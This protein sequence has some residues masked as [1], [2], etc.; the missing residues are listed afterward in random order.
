MPGGTR[1]ILE[2]WRNLFAQVESAMGWESV[3]QTWPHLEITARLAAR[4]LAVLRTMMERG[5]NA[6]LTSSAGRLFD[7]VAASLGLGG[8]TI[9]YEGQAAIELEA[10]AAGAIGDA[11][12]GYRLGLSNTGAGRVLDPGPLWHTLFAELAAGVAPAVIAARFHL[13]FCDALAEL[14]GQI[15]AE[16]GLDRVALSGGVFQNRLVLEGLCVRL[17]ERGLT[18][19]T[20]AQVPANDGGLSLGQAVVAAAKSIQPS[21]GAG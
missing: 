2:P 10:L 15:A 19:L 6:P 17:R 1:A 18:P 21:P 16:Q 13:G 3:L 5:L 12:A 4:P 11:G 14:T 8:E 9:A 20:H 7:A